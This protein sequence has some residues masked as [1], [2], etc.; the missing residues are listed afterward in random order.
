MR[1]LSDLEDFLNTFIIIGLMSKACILGC[2]IIVTG[3]LKGGKMNFSFLLIYIR[4]CKR[5]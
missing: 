4:A 1:R 3:D 5:G 2:V